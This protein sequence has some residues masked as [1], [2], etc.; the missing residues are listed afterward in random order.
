MENSVTWAAAHATA[1]AGVEQFMANA[2]AFIAANTEEWKLD[3]DVD[4]EVTN[5]VLRVHIQDGTIASCTED[6]L[7]L[8]RNQHVDGGWGNTRDDATSRLRSTAFCTQM[9]LRANRVLRND[10]VTATIVRAIDYILTAQLP[11]GSW[12]DDK[13]PML[14]ACSVSVG[15]LLFAVNQPDATQRMRQTLERGMEFITSQRQPD[16]LWYYKP[17]KSPVTISAHLL[18]KCATFGAPPQQLIDSA[19]ALLG[20]QAAA[21]YWDRE[22]IDHTCDA[23]RCLMLTSSVTGDAALIRATNEALV[24]SISWV[25]AGARD[26]GLGNQP[27]AKPHVERTCD[28]VDT[29]LKYKLF[30]T[31]HRSILSFWR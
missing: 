18:Q 27:G 17:N 10:A 13:W 14:D 15:T 21:G 29:I 31:E 8:C 2:Y 22:N 6:V 28:G 23:S 7:A 20:L 25:V 16:H 26:G 19:Y 3:H 5:H 30:S 4:L 1:P 11:D 24:R 9:L 12:R